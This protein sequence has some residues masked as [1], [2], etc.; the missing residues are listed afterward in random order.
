MVGLFL[1][2][3]AVAVVIFIHRVRGGVDVRAATLRFLVWI[4]MLTA[5]LIALCWVTGERPRWHWGD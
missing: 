2:G 4:A 3:V 1:A 5:A